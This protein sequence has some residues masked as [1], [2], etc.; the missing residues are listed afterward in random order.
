MKSRRRVPGVTLRVF[1]DLE[2]TAGIDHDGDVDLLDLAACQNCFEG[3]AATTCAQG[4]DEF[5]LTPDNA[6]DL[7]DFPEVHALFTGP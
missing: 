7:S 4:C 6:L 1:D 5:D 3:E 2:G